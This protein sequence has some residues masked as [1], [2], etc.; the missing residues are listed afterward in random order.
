[1]RRGAFVSDSGEPELIYSDHYEHIALPSLCIAGGRDRIANAAIM[2]EAFYERIRST[3]KQFL[4][5]E[6]LAHGEF[7]VAPVACEWVHPRI[8]EWLES[9]AKQTRGRKGGEN[10]N[11]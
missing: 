8:L 11:E 1:V 5:F 3:D 6:A 10:R 7:E 9:R 4:L 2:R